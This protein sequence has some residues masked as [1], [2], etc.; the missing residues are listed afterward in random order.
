MHNVQV[1]LSSVT[2]YIIEMHM[3]ATSVPDLEIQ[4]LGSL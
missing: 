3:I 2:V 4:E 1:S